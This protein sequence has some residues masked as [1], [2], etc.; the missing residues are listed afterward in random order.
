MLTLGIDLG[1]TKVAAV[2]YD[3]ENPETGFFKCAQ[4]PGHCLQLS[5][6]SSSTGA[7]GRSMTL[8]VFQTPER[9]RRTIRK[10]STPR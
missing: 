4:I 2:L 1:T 8:M 3:T 9:R 6:T 10:A 7:G 5:V